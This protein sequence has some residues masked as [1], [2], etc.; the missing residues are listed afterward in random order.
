MFENWKRYFY[1]IF[2]FVFILSG[3]TDTQVNTVPPPPIADTTLPSAPP[4][5]EEKDIEESTVGPEEDELAVYNVEPSFGSTSGL[6]QVEI[7][8]SGFRGGLLVSFNDSLA[9][10]TFVLDKNRIIVLTPPH[11]AGLVDVKVFDSDGDDMVQLESAYLYQ[12]PIEAY[13]VEPYEGTVFGGDA[14]TITGRGF[15]ENTSVIFG[16]RPVVQSILVDENTLSIITPS[17]PEEGPVDVY[18]TNESGNAVIEDGFN[19]LPI[20]GLSQTEEFKIY[21]IQPSFGPLEGGQ[22]A[23]I[24]GI[25]FKE[26]MGVYIGSLP[27]SSISVI[28]E[29][30]ITVTVPPG[31][32]G[33]SDV[34]VLSQDVYSVLPNGFLYQSDMQLWVVTPP[35]G[36]FAGGTTVSLIGSGF[37][38]QV[39]VLFDNVP[40]THVEVVSPTEI[41]CKTP[42]GDVGSVDVALISPSLGTL[43]L[44]EGYTYYNPASSF[45]GT[46]GEPVEGAVN[47]SVID[48][49]N[50]AGMSDVF[51]MLW[52]SPDTPYQ[53][54]TNLNGQITFSGDDL[55][56]EQMVSASKAG[57]A[58][59]SVI[60]YDAENITL[61]MQPTAPPSPGSPSGIEPGVYHGNVINTAKYV[62]V[63]IGDC[64]TKKDTPGTLCDP[65]ETN[66]DCA[67]LNC[68]EIP[69]QGDY[70]T[71]HCVN[72][73]DCPDTF[74]CIPMNGVD[75][76]QCVPSVGRVTAF[77]DFSRSGIFGYDH[78]PDPGIEVNEDYSFSI[79]MLRLDGVPLFGEFAI[80]CYGGIVSHD[81]NKFT[82]YV[83]GI[84]RHVF[85]EPGSQIYG[86]IYLNTVLK[87]E[88]SITFEN[89]VINPTGPHFHYVWAYLDLGSDGV[90]RFMNFLTS[91]G[92]GGLLMDQVPQVLTGALY[93]ADYTIFGG[94]FSS[95][96]DNLPYSLTLHQKIKDPSELLLG[97]MLQVPQNIIPEDNG[98]MGEDYSISWTTLPGP[99][100]HFSLAEISIPTLMP[101]GLEYIPEWTM[102][103]D[104]YVEDILLPDFPDIDGSPGITKGEK[105]LL[106]IRVYKEGFNINNYSGLELNTITWKS[107]AVDRIS[108]TKD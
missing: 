35:E 84:D 41:R 107:W 92:S 63:K 6:A 108:F 99:T 7:I 28:D 71:S 46:W 105:S 91:N 102:I 11:P 26:G 81:T 49:S 88:F 2:I 43:V 21:E 16:S 23:E 94:T 57:Y 95:T 100:P 24:T 103:N 3:C 8:G 70:C 78:L 54:Y 77:C 61:F 106:L 33:F 36:S 89:A 10:D 38:A 1:R 67:G 40:A 93:D 98:T 30:T 15:T 86:D 32:P 101:W 55:D 47:V 83:L 27:A 75:E 73:N 31:S 42:P 60:E 74:M 58:S 59:A 65:C 68:T 5:V 37:P 51:V 97:P 50:G 22:Q 29:N 4:I 48:A 18:I 52:T 44:S 72:N 13:E 19:Y 20:E 76:Q 79:T 34:R 25:G 17:A 62:P 66:T 69:L 56:G 53:G 87:G 82:P 90:I 14:V 12:S 96:P 39:S 85:F 9:L 104:H 80:Y 64:D 45:G